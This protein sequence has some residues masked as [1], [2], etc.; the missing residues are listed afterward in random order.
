LTITTIQLE[1]ISNCA[2]RVVNTLILLLWLQNSSSFTAQYDVS[3][4]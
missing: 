4:Q 3:K 2:A 1:L